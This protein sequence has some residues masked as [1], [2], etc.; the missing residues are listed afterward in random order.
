MVAKPRDPAVFQAMQE[1]AA[2]TGDMAV[3]PGVWEGYHNI[4]HQTLEIFRLAAILPEVTH[5]AKVRPPMGAGGMQQCLCLLCGCCHAATARHMHRSQVT[6]LHVLESA[7]SLAPKAGPGTQPK[8]GAQVDD[9]TY[10]RVGPLLDRIRQLPA[11]PSYLGWVENPGG[12]PHRD[13]KSQVLVC[14]CRSELAAPQPL[15]SC[16]LQS[17][18]RAHMSAACCSTAAVLVQPDHAIHALA[19]IIGKPQ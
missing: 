14:L 13:R 6:T 16:M 17:C 9:D 12:G 3:L 1:E 10:V 5:V 18:P 4:T 11:G 7:C 8:P 19:W 15:S 2:A